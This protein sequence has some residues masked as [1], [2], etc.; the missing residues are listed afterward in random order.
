[1]SPRPPDRPLPIEIHPEIGRS[2]TLPGRV[3]DDPEVFRLQQDRVFARS[4]QLVEGA[5]RVRAP[6][7]VLPFTLLE[8]CLDEPLVLVR[9]DGGTLRA[10]SNVCTHRA[11][12]VVEG[13]GHARFLRCRYHGRRFGLDGCFRSMPEFDGVEGF[14]SADDDLPRLPLECWGPFRFTGLDPEPDFG[15][16]IGPV[17]ERTGWMPLDEFRFDPA[18]SRDYLIDANWAL[19]CD[20]YLEEFHIPYV[21]GTS[22]GGTLDYDRYRTER[23]EWGNLQFGIANEGEPGFE[24]PSGHPDEGERV[25]AFYFWLFPNLMLNFYPWGLSVNIV[26]PL[27]PH[28]TRVSFRSWVWREELREQG[29]GADLHRVEMEDEEVVESVQRGVRSRLYRRGRFSPRREVGT[30]HFHLLLARAMGGT[31]PPH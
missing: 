8:G 20:N 14:P 17:E 9:D 16:W 10:L 23:F 2:R 6:G 30:H 12:L 31:E 15:D 7:H 1:M 22:L 21:H 4:W 5:E 18:S 24:L 26:R 28:R 3:F 25:A 19:Y 27:G 29:A 11:A 13:E